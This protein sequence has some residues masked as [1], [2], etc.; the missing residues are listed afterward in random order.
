MKNKIKIILLIFS[1]ILLTGCS[2]NY[3][4]NINEDLSIDEN[5]YLTID[6]SDTAYENTLKI[7]DENN[8][9]KDKYD[10]SINGDDIIIEYNDKFET[11][12]DY[13]INSNIYHQL[14]DEIT[15]N[16]TDKYIDLYTNQ[17]LKLKEDNDIGNTNDL[18]V[19]Q[20][21]V[22]V[23]FKMISNNSDIYND[24][25][26]TWTIDKNTTQKKIS[27]NFEMRPSGFPYSQVIMIVTLVVVITIFTII[28]VRR[29]RN[30]QKI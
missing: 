26:Y 24:D 17:Y 21:N 23:P 4:I 30:S 12:D 14:I 8:I 15:Y 20:I 22:K 16:K 27:M 10:V 3:N 29:F 28:L 25:I 7:F 6:N 19:I 18:D 11:I 2:G 1:I 13:I 9:D 5:L